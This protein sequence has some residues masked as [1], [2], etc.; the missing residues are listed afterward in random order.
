MTTPRLFTPFT[1]RSITLPNRIVISPMC[2]YSA[3]DGLADSFHFA[4]L[5]KFAMGGA[6]CVFVEATAVLKDARITYGDLGLW[7]DAQTEALRPIAS[8]LRARGSVPAIQ[9]AH[10]GRKASSQRPWHGNG[11]LDRTD[12]AR[13]EP[14]V[15]TVAPSALPIAEGWLVPHEA[16]AADMAEIVAAFAASARRAHAAGFDVVELHAA[17]GYLLNSFLS[18]IANKRTDQYGGSR[19]NRMRFPLA[20]VDAVRAAWPA[21]KPLF[22]RISSVDGVEGGWELDDSVA[23]ALELK[24]RGV[25]A[26]DCSSGGIGGSA[27]AARIVRA[28][29]F[30]V[31]FAAEI[32]KR[33]GIATQAVGLILTADQAEQILQSDSA[34]LVAIAREALNDPFWPRHAAAHFGVDEKYEQW[35]PQYGWWLSRRAKFSV[36]S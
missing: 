35:P 22:V 15:R 4:H 32:R 9:L 31:P 26:I 14:N 20:V 5:A 12:F 33:A 27:T 21:E 29:G 8:F 11:P 36:K 3:T 25:D 30:Q 34:D 10:A 23:F 2:M 19:A 7:N 1:L 6:G 13:G 16:T 28:P 24:Q 18:P 17:H